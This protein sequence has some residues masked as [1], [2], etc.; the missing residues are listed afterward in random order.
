MAL[1]HVLDRTALLE[2]I[3]SHTKVGLEMA[4]IWNVE[5][6]FDHSDVE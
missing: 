1:R 5:A 4:G 6:S 3:L 2:M